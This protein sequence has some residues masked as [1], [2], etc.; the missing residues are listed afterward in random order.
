MPAAGAI[1]PYVSVTSVNGDVFPCS[2]GMTFHVTPKGKIALVTVTAKSPYALLK[3]NPPGGVAAV[4]ADKSVPWAVECEDGEKS[5]VFGACGVISMCEFPFLEKKDFHLDRPHI[6]IDEFKATFDSSSHPY[7]MIKIK[8]QAHYVRPGEH[9]IEHRYD[10][11]P[12]CGSETP[13]ET[14]EYYDTSF[15][16]Y[17]VFVSYMGNETEIG[18]SLNNTVVILSN[19]TSDP[20]HPDTQIT[21]TIM[22]INH[23]KGCCIGS[24]DK[25]VP[26]D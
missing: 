19:H 13:F 12:Q 14:A 1:N 11:C 10:R 3:P 6:K 25:T 17:K 20:P 4:S 2:D 7:G 8:Y 23:E 26:I 9:V 21:L 5:N 22:G 18:S 24:F 15:D 16:E